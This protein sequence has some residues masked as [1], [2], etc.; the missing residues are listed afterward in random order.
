MK[1]E[2]LNSKQHNRNQFDCGTSVLNIYLQRIAN[3]DQKKNLSRIYVLAKESQIV[4]YYSISAHSVFG[5]IY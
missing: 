4:G 5:N 3:Q 1:F 2:L